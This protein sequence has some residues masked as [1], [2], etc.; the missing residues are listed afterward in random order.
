MEDTGPALGEASEAGARATSA[1]S[2]AVSGFVL[3]MDE[4]PPAA[5]WISPDRPHLDITADFT[6]QRVGDLST[7]MVPSTSSAR[8]L[9]T[10]GGSTL[11]LVKTNGQ[12]ND[13]HRVRACLRPLAASLRSATRVR[14]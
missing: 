8:S 7:E 4:C 12:R 13:H 2:T 1:V 5:R 14:R 6:Y 11:H 10:M 3:P 9:Y